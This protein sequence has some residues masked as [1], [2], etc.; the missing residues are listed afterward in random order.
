M[1]RDR[2][3]TIVGFGLSDSYK[4]AG[5]PKDIDMIGYLSESWFRGKKS[6]RFEILSF[7]D[8]GR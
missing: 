6:Y 1:I 2:D 3:I 5:C 7:A 4:A 8:E